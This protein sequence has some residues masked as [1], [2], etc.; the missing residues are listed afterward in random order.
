MNSYIEAR[1]N[2]IINTER[3]INELRDIFDQFATMVSEQGEM[4]TRIDEDTSDVVANVEGAQ[5][6]LLK[7]W[8]SV[9]GNKWLVV[10]QPIY[11]ACVSSN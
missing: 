11:P 1:S 4:I 9:S 3:T 6:E 8:N 5:R 10:R 7:Y 2:A